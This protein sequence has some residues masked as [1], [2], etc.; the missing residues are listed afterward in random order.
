MANGKFTRTVCKDHD[1]FQ[2]GAGNTKADMP[3]IIG[4]DVMACNG[5]IHVIDEVI[6]P[7]QLT[8]L[9]CP[10][11]SLKHKKDVLKKYSVRLMMVPPTTNVPPHTTQVQRCGRGVVVPPNVKDCG[12]C[13]HACS[14]RKQKKNVLQEKMMLYSD[15]DD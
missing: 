12:V 3:K 11:T 4:A 10:V 5:V 6:L 13:G 8:Q 14:I 1:V 15:D 2:R 7:K 9:F